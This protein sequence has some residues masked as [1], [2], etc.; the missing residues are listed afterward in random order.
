MMV[1]NDVDGDGDDDGD[2]YDDDVNRKTT[3]KK[4]IKQ[5]TNTEHHIY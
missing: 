2:G 4:N 3:A 5:I 1:C